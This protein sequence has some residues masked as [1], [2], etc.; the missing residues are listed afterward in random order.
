MRNETENVESLIITY[1]SG[2]ATNEEKLS[3]E[4]WLAEGEL[5][6]KHFAEVADIW[7]ASAINKPIESNTDERFKKL[8][9]RIKKQKQ[10]KFNFLSILRYAA[11]FIIAL[12]IGSVI[13]LYLTSDNGASNKISENR[14]IAP[15]GSKTN[16]ILPDG[17]QVWL[18]A[19]SSITY[20]DDFLSG[21]NREIKLIGEAYF[22]VS[23]NKEKPF[24]VKTN[25]AV[26]RALG[27]S[28]NVKAYPE[29]PTVEATLVE[30]SIAVYKIQEEK[31]EIILKPNQQIVINKKL[32]QSQDENAIKNKESNSNISIA[33]NS[34][35]SV[36]KDIN[37]SKYTSWKDRSWI[38]EN[39][40]LGSL[41]KKLE[42]RYD[43]KIKFENEKYQELRF[44]GTLMD[45]SLEQVLEVISFA[46]PISFNVDGKT[47]LLCSK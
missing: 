29:E 1:L 12:G 39:E 14:I 4:N 47:V 44:S 42:R 40:E 34:D 21:R 5:N 36:Q 41:A 33:N 38:I 16:L 7:E 26:V 17:S 25:D 32:I 27:T 9:E 35:I 2:N 18:N 37:V 11:I 45:E 23:K 6:R 19:G 46:S 8:E 10:I 15:K 31:E 24:I 20:Q 13:T 22:K 3:V 43:I 28:F 30:G